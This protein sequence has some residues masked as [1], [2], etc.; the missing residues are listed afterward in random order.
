ME[1]GGSSVEAGQR[2]LRW[3]QSELF[4]QLCGDERLE[5][6]LRRFPSLRRKL[7]QS[8]TSLHAPLTVLIR[9]GED[10]DL[11]ADFKA[12]S[13]IQARL[14]LQDVPQLHD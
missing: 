14:K 8:L 10:R 4:L 9:P 13:V 12:C 7:A 6:R 1:H 5:D 2:D 11:L 3:W